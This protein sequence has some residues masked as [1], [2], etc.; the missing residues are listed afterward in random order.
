MNAPACEGKG[1][2]LCPACKIKSVRI[3]SLELRVAR[4]ERK[5]RRLEAMIS[6][7]R[8]YAGGVLHEARKILSQRSGVPRGQWAFVKGAASVAKNVLRIVGG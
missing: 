3:L 8:R 6:K 7:V 2:N 4:L 1:I 5:V